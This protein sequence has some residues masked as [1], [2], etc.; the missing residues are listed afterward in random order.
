MMGSE[1][2]SKPDVADLKHMALLDDFSY[3]MLLCSCPK[4]SLPGAGVL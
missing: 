1:F 3:L 2:N 4:P